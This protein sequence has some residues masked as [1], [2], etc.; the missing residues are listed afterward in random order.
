MRMQLH[1]DDACAR[2]PGGSPF[3]SESS[4]ARPRER[5]AVGARRG[6]FTKVTDR[7]LFVIERQQHRSPSRQIGRADPAEAPRSSPDAS[8]FRWPPSRCCLE[9]MPLV[10]ETASVHRGRD[11]RAR[12][13]A[14]SVYESVSAGVLAA[15]HESD[16]RQAPS[17]PRTRRQPR[18]RVRRRSSELIG[19]R[20]KRPAI[21]ASGD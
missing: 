19:N 8:L 6:C 13:G 17:P 20:A 3:A 1:A 15:R 11:R 5:R 2:D 9:P 21:A 16:D 7:K 18:T 4:W 12:S 14:R 10:C